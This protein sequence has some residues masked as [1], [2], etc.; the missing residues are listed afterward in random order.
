MGWI[1]FW[2]RGIKKI[3][4]NVKNRTE[5]W[6]YTLPHHLRPPQ[7][8]SYLKNRFWHKP[9]T[10]KPRSLDHDWC[11]MVALLPHVMFE[12]L[13]RFIEN[14]C[15][16]HVDWY[17]DWPGNKFEHNSKQKYGMDELLDLY[18]WWNVV[19]LKEYP[20]VEDIL[21]KEAYKNR[22]NIYIDNNYYWNPQFDTSEKGLVWHR[23]V[24]A[25]TKLDEIMYEELEKRMKR[26]VEVRSFM[27][28]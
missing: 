22:P 7:I 23:C 9:T 11:D 3:H 14:E 10:I 27:W 1:S 18:Y 6:Y 19:Y 15:P 24:T 20:D 25:A 5:N 28:V 21:W 13:S 26:L 2:T 12:C 17:S 4:S 8:I 16:G